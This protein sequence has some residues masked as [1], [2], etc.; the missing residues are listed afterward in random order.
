M[1]VFF[2]DVIKPDTFDVT[3]I[4]EVQQKH[5]NTCALSINGYTVVTTNCSNNKQK[6]HKFVHPEHCYSF[7][8]E[9][10]LCWLKAEK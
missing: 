6:Y 9:T 4:R 7:F 8:A 1:C 5:L 2:Q 3:G 10:L